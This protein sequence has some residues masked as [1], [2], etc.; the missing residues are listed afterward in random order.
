MEKLVYL[1]GPIAGISYE[2]CNDW[3]EYVTN[4]LAKDGITCISPMRCKDLS[5]TTKLMKD[6]G[7]GNIMTSGKGI[8]TRDRM[9]VERCHVM[10]ANLTGA[11]EVSIGT[12]IEYGWADA[13]R[14]PIITVMENEGNVH[15][16]NFI[17]EF[18]GF[19]TDK[20][21]SGIFV[22]RGLLAA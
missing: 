22:A 16:H 2:G 20:L 9:D 1:A 5:D 18:S 6:S 7:G 3:R 13:Y 8:V 11:E 17:R 21:D 10:F 4:E 14:H 15:E 12:M 19:R